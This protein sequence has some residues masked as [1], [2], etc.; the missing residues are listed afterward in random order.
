MY[1]CFQ[2]N[3]IAKQYVELNTVSV[4]AIRPFKSFALRLQPLYD[5]P[6][7]PTHHSYRSACGMASL[8]NEL[9]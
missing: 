8:E 5:Y 4:D 6:L 9:F 7:P 2:Y 3:V 1:M